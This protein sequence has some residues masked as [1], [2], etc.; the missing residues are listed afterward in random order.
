METTT[1]P[2]ERIAEEDYRSWLINRQVTLDEFNGASLVERST[3]RTQFEQQQRLQQQPP[4]PP[5]QQLLSED[6]VAAL[7][8]FAKDYASKKNTVVLSDATFGSKRALL[9]MFFEL[10]EKAATWPNMPSTSTLGE[11]PVFHWHDSNE[12]SPQ[13][14]TAYMKYLKQNI[15]LPDSY[16]FGDVQPIRSL[17]DVEIHGV[18]CETRQ[19]LRGTTDVVITKIENI[20]HGTIRN[21]VDAQLELKKP[22][23]LASKDHSPQ[24]IAEHFA[25]SYLNPMQGVVSALTDLGSS[26]TFYWFADCK[27]APGGVALYRHVLQG[28]AAAEAAKYVLENTITCESSALTN[29][30][31]TAT[32]TLPTTFSSRLSFEDLMQKLS[33]APRAKRLRSGDYMNPDSAGGNLG[34]H[35]QDGTGDAGGKQ[36]GPASGSTPSDQSHAANDETGFAEHGRDHGDSRQHGTRAA[37]FLRLLAPQ[38][39]SEVADQLDLLDMVDED[40]QYEIVRS[41]AAD[42]IVPHMTG[43]RC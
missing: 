1:T 39:N 9:S 37:E 3:L 7:T 6:T 34:P 25:A 27:D 41:F 15:L 20:Q 11:C 12:D 16:V 5:P 21:S 2:W 8:L 17:L 42:Y 33:Q 26:W 4:A 22:R 36:P 19:R 18:D 10:P 14:R 23:N 35:N 31:A 24:V 43:K 32:T 38:Y 13:N 28:T 40:E 30:T 29:R